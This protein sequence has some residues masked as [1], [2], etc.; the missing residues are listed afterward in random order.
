[1]ATITLKDT[2]GVAGAFV[3]LSGE[4]FR[5]GETV[6]LFVGGQTA[7]HLPCDGNGTFSGQMQ[8]PTGI[9]SGSFN[10]AAVGNTSAITDNN[11]FTVS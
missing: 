9:G 10:A 1:M 5:T 7:G 2:S 6:N 4:G 3:F 8:V 11:T